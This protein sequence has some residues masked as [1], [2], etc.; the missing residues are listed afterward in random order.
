MGVAREKLRETALRLAPEL[1]AAMVMVTVC[2][3]VW[4]RFDGIVRPALLRGWLAY[5]AAC[6]V[7]RIASVAIVTSR[8]DAVPARG[9]GPAGRAITFAFCMGIVGSV[10][11]LMPAAD[12]MLR[13]ILIILCMWFIAMVIILNPD[14]LA[15]IGALAVVGSMAAFALVYRL[16]YSGEIAGFLVMEGAVLIMIRRSGQR[17]ARALEAALATVQAERDAKTRFLAS[18]SHDL[19]QPLQAAR[20]YF[21][22]ALASGPGQARAVEGARSAFRNTQALLDSMLEHLR[23][24][25]DAMPARV[26]PMSLRTAAEAT[27]REQAPSLRATTLDLRLSGQAWAMADAQLVARIAG[28]L[29]S[30]IVA[31]AGATRALVVA[32]RRGGWAELWFLDNGVGV[33]PPDAGRLFEDYFQGSAGAD[34]KVG[35]FGI[36]L[37][38]VRRMAALMGGSVAYDPRWRRGSAFVL[39]LP[40]AQVPV[41]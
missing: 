40:V 33:A 24:E 3:F 30:N 17:A 25:A 23:L 39:R 31:H 21:D 28:N 5:M 29:L 32:R 22:Q 38:S 20:L 12:P 26:E 10:W 4:A 16:P 35:G 41:S 27:V 15:V 1:L 9:R 18:A 7:A 34:R 2:L 14:R 6:I 36:G 11:L 13:L 37:A 19:Q 8:P